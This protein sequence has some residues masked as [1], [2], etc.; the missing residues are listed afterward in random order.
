MTLTNEQIANK[1]ELDN[2]IFY[3]NHIPSRS[4]YS[5]STSLPS[6]I[7]SSSPLINVV[8]EYSYK[9]KGKIDNFTL[10]YEG[11][12]HNYTSTFSANFPQFF[13]TTNTIKI[14]SKVARALRYIPAK[15]LKAIHPNT[16][17]A[18]E[19]CLLF[20]RNLNSTYFKSSANGVYNS[21]K[22]LH[23]AYLR[24]F[25]STSSM[26]YKLIREALE[27]PL[28]SGSILECD[29]IY[30]KK[31]KCFAYRLG[32]SYRNK[33]IRDYKLKTEEAV[34]LLVKN[35]E[36]LFQKAIQN[37]ICKNLFIFYSQITFPTVEEIHAE[38]KRL[39]KVGFKTKKGKKLTYLNKHKK[40]VSIHS[41]IS[42]VE[43]DIKLYKNLTDYGL[44]IPVP[45]GE[46]SGGRVVDSI[47]LMPSWIRSLITIGGKRLD[48]C[49]YSCFHP[50][51][52]ASIYGVSYEVITH[53]DIAFK[54][55]LD[56]ATVKKEHLSFFNKRYDQMVKS[57][58]YK[59]YMNDH[60]KM[61]K[62]IIAEKFKTVHKHK[63]TSRRFFAK[64]VDIMKEVI[65]QLNK[66]GI[67]VG[68]VYDALLSHP[69]YTKRLTEV[70]N[71]VALE[72][73]VKSNTR[74]TL[75]H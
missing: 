36:R 54:Y 35:N 37:P 11:K 43:D 71:K 62:E 33:G 2:Y 65:I 23:S 64:E 31:Q 38:A 66:E 1:S 51:I 16:E 53:K 74:H 6:S 26:T 50:N 61:M 15:Y 17:V 47:T 28:K 69:I 56:E 48:E 42:F 57:P 8:P 13:K 29:Y 63:I 30:E 19:Y 20:L 59:W 44:R 67:F 32:E 34:N 60:K 9:K 25:F 45:G 10:K 4:F 46:S 75:Q 73:G 7:L 21:W 39:I 41:N 52:A 5:S 22:T 18:K 14:P 49:D 70:M 27:W 3:S 58:L 40:N 72:H 24:E 12:K 68:Y 55:G